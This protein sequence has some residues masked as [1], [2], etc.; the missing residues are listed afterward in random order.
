MPRDRN[1]C[2]YWRHV[3][4]RSGAPEL[5]V[6][7]HQLLFALSGFRNLSDQRDL[8]ILSPVCRQ[9]FF[10]IFCVLDHRPQCVL[11]MFQE[12]NPRAAT[13]AQSMTGDNWSE[14]C[15]TLMADQGPMVGIFYVSAPFFSL[16]LLRQGCS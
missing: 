8:R 16:F 9:L 4:L 13:T 2:H 12:S 7:F 5:F 6:L 15:R 3:F 14:D 10:Y 11:E 1:L